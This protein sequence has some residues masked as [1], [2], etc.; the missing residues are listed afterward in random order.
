M[1]KEIIIKKGI[2]KKVLPRKSYK[3][4]YVTGIIYLPKEY[5]GKKV[6]VVVD[7]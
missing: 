1:K 2:I 7:E 5:I 3:G 4:R 6:R